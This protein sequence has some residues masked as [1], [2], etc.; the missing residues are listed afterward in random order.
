L[1]RAVDWENW[2]WK[3]HKIPLAGFD[4]YKREKKLA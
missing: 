1:F 4:E 3:A 2:L